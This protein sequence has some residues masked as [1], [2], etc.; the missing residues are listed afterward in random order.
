MIRAGELGKIEYIY[1]SRLNLGKLRIRGEY[2][3][4]FRHLMIFLRS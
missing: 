3:V 4:E 2:T 1:S